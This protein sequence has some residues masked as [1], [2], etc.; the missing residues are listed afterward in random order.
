MSGFGAR[1]LYRGY[2][3]TVFAGF[4]VILASCGE[5]SEPDPSTISETPAVLG[6]P[7]PPTVPRTNTELFPATGS[8]GLVLNHCAS[9]HAVACTALGQR[10]PSRWSAV[11]ESH[12]NYIPGLSIEDRGKIFDYLRR[13]FNDT[14]PEP[15][16]PPEL[17]EGGCPTL[18]WPADPE[19]PAAGAPSSP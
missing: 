4:V 11:E 1:R 10:S 16:V 5:R 15:N 7:A 2:L 3:T 19:P 14:L 8:R 12:A 6:A 13:D 9:C 18:T 17:L